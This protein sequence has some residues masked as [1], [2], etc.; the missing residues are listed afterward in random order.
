MKSLLTGAN[1]LVGHTILAQLNLLSQNDLDLR[2][3]DAVFGYFDKH[4]PDAVIHTAARVGGLGAN[5]QYM[6]D[7]YTDNILINTNV[8]DAAQRNGV[9]Q[10][11]S[12]LS[13]CI[14]PDMATSV[15][16]EDM[17]HEGEP[18]PS[19]FG[20]AYAKRMLEVQSRAISSQHGLG[21][22]CVIPTNIY[23]PHD[24]F[25]LNS[26]HVIP[27]L[28]HKCYLAE[29]YG[30]NFMVWGSGK[31]LREFIFSHDVGEL[32]GMLMQRYRSPYT[33]ILSP[34]E[35]VSIGRVA[36]IIANAMEFKGKIVYDTGYSDGQFRK[37]TCNKKLQ[38]LIPDYEFTPLEEG[39]RF[40]VDWFKEN[41]QTCRK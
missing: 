5:M 10:V 11:V 17:L 24:N 36:E 31:P 8:L 6:S 25:N 32:V 38:S 2:D 37:P 41:Y 40:T 33:V 30:T 14:F 20:Y 9:E 13:T 15:L 3:R 19:N 4:R 28:I 16:T 23:G 26:G 39:I 35:E 12:F 27:S 18:H 34:S 21:Y 7:F 22:S 1:G 29:K